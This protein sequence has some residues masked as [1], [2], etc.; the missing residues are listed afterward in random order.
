MLR[1]RRPRNRTKPKPAKR[2]RARYIDI[3]EGPVES[4]RCLRD[5][6]RAAG[7]KARYGESPY[8]GHKYV[9]IQIGGDT[10]FTKR[11]VASALGR[12]GWKFQAQMLRRGLVGSTF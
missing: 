10:G 9:E 4:A 6:M 7:F 12:N 3:F 1:F 2:N 8:V 5:T 11:N